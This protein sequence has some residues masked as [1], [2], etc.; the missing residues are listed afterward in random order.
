MHSGLICQ[1]CGGNANP[2]IK[3]CKFCGATL[4][5]KK[6]LTQKTTK[7]FQQEPPS[8][9]NMENVTSFLS[10]SVKAAGDRLSGDALSFVADAGKAV[11]DFQNL[12]ND[13]K[14][15][16]NTGQKLTRRS[17]EET[18]YYMKPRNTN[19]PKDESHELNLCISLQNVDLNSSILTEI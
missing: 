12:Q 5:S 7:N 1:V 15:K 14:K 11:S 10:S 16:K 8:E 4:T 6:I 17:E 13:S 2:A 9:A 18:P 3:V 19:E